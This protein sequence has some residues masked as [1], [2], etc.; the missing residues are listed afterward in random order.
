MSRQLTQL[1]KRRL[2]SVTAPREQLAEFE[3]MKYPHH[4]RVDSCGMLIECVAYEN[5]VRPL[6]TP[7]EW[8]VIEDENIGTACRVTQDICEGGISISPGAHQ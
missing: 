6:M 3:R 2:T 5:Q 7:A 4:R 8:A 1:E